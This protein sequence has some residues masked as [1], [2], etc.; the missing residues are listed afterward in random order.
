MLA[1]ILG[2]QGDGV[3]AGCCTRKKVENERH[4]LFECPLYDRSLIAKYYLCFHSLAGQQ[5]DMRSFMNSPSDQVEIA[6]LL[7]DMFAKRKLKLE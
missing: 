4:F 7:H 6:W 2:P 3:I 5:C 1:G